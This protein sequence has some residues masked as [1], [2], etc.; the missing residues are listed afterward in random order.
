MK[1]ASAAAMAALILPVAAVA[2]VAPP[3][4][5]NAGA[6]LRK[7]EAP[8]GILKQ[9]ER[10]LT[11]LDLA[12]APDGSV[13]TCT[14][15]LSSK[16]VELD[17]YACAYFKQ[18]ARYEPINRGVA[19]STPRTTR[20]F[21]VWAAPKSADSKSSKASAAIPRPGYGFWV[22]SDDLPKGALS[23]GQVVV[24]S[25]SLTVSAEGRVAGCSVTLP[26]DRPDLDQRVCDLML[27]RA[28][29]KPARDVDGK[30][31]RGMDWQTIRWEVP[32]D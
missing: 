4:L 3:R 32:I 22:N 26:S 1:I 8:T 21:W 31:V 6:W 27:A 13:A 25:V 12:I 10:A 19:N 15:A 2:A 20:Q 17:Q 5:I 11:A 16:S 7:L 18:N 14:V 24:S 23:K 28:R 29:Y 9:G 30:P